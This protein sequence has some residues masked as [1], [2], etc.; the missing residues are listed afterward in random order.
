MSANLFA[1]FILFVGLVIYTMPSFAGQSSTTQYHGFVSQSYLKSNNY[2]FFGESTEGSF[3]FREFGINASFK[4]LTRLRASGQ[5]L[6][7]EAGE[8]D[9][10]LL[11]VDFALLDYQLAASKL[12]TTGIRVGRIKNP[13]GIYNETRD[14][15]FTRPGIILPQSIYFD[16][17]RDIA[18]SSDGV[19]VYSL[20]SSDNSDYQLQI[21]AARPRIGTNT[22]EALFSTKMPGN[23]S[24]NTSYLFRVSADIFSRKLKIA[25]TEI[26]LSMNYEPTIAEPL[27][28]ANIEF[29]P[30]ILSAQYSMENYQFTAEYARRAFKFNN[31]DIYLPYSFISGESYYFQLAYFPMAYLGAYIRYDVTFLNKEDKDGIKLAQ[32]SGGSKPAYSQ[33]AFDYTLGL[34]YTPNRSWV[35]M[36]E[37]HWIEGTAWIPVQDNRTLTSSEKN[38]IL[39]SILVS[40]RF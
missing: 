13:I 36:F 12:T 8:N 34:R 24:P 27:S 35:I 26:K 6:F 21:G 31:L 3:R 40:Y 29:S 28:N 14:V 38:W 17:V 7:R 5:L 11:R 33:Y 16:R 32:L 1:R 9:P 23:L 18:L 19:H 39:S 4:P 25:Y 37:N 2:N 10:G 20:F 30:R 22:E 15:S